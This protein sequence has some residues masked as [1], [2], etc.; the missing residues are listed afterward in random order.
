MQSF[1]TDLLEFV[2]LEEMFGQVA[3]LGERI[4]ASLNCAN[5]RSL[6]SMSS[7]MVIKVVC[8][9]KYLVAILVFTLH[10]FLLP[11]GDWVDV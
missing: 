6:P 4:V 5:E 7:E 11:L 2:E 8:F 1:G 3:L 10:D 9:E